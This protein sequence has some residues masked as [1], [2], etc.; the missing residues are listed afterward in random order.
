MINKEIVINR[1][2]LIKQL[3]KIGVDQSKQFEPLSALSI[4]SFHDSI[5]MFL[6][7]LAEHKN[8]T[9]DKFSFL[10]YWEKIP[11]LTLKESMRNLNARRVNIKHKGLLPSKADVEISRIN[12]MDFFEQNV[13]SH[14]EIKFEDISLA[15]LIAYENVKVMVIESQHAFE[16]KDY[17]LCIEKI[18]IAFHELLYSYEKTKSGNFR[19]SPFFFG[20]DFHFDSSFFMGVKDR[21]MAK[22]ID[23]VRESIT[24]I[25]DAIKITSLGIDYRKFVKFKLLTPSVHKM[26]GGNHIAQLFREKKWTSNNCQ[27]CIDFVIDCALKLQEFDFDIE[28]LED[29]TFTMTIS[30][31]E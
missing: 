9:S 20:K 1:L 31:D 30:N 19:Y 25:Q 3:Y 23:N 24:S 6:K 21:D 2:A 11:T 26:V 29:Q 5:E 28:E 7:L 14:F 13:E 22:F 15:S 17:E 27:Y 16:N 18:S 10:E 8:I 12:T 4:L